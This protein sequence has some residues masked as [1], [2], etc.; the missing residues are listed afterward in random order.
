MSWYRKFAGKSI[1]VAPEIGKYVEGEKALGSHSGAAKEAIERS[2]KLATEILSVYPE[3]GAIVE[4]S[5][6]IDPYQATC[7]VEVQVLYSPAVE[8]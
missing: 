5:G 2:G 8:G 7:K 3:K 6:H 4:L 1:D